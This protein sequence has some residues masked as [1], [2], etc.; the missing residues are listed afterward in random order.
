MTDV[1]TIETFSGHVG[2]KFLIHYG[3]SQTADLEL[4]SATDVGSS[5][6]QSQFSLV[7]LGPLNGPAAQGIFRLEH[8]KLG[9]LDLFLVPIARNNDGLSYEAIFNRFLE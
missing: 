5:N 6:M 8:D 2:T 1:F 9:S 4:L 7:F 3:D